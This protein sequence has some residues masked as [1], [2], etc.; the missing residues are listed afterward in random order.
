MESLVGLDWSELASGTLAPI[1][2]WAVDGRPPPLDEA[3]A[4]LDEAVYAEP[5]R[6]RPL[7]A[8]VEAAIALHLASMGTA[9]PY[10]DV[11]FQSGHCAGRL[12]RV[13]KRYLA[14]AEECERLRES[15]ALHH[16]DV[17]RLSASL[18]KLQQKESDLILEAL[19]TDVGDVD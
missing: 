12:E 9:E 5:E 1:G 7:L 16:D 3:L 2:D 4:E 13:R 14:L 10:L 11:A 8:S 15:D 18:A 6:V 19:W 17:A